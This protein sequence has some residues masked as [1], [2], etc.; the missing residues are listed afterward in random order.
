LQKTARSS[1][2]FRRLEAKLDEARLQSFESLVEDIH[3]RIDVREFTFATEQIQAARDI[4]QGAEQLRRLEE[5]EQRLRGAGRYE[6]RAI[7][8]LSPGAAASLEVDSPA[9]E[10]DHPAGPRTGAAV[11]GAGVT[12]MISGVLEIRTKQ[13]QNSR[14]ESGQHRIGKS[15]YKDY[16]GYIEN[17]PI[18][19][20]IN[21]TTPLL[22]WHGK[23]DGSVKWEQS[24]ELHLALRRLGKKHTMLIY[25]GEGHALAGPEACK[26]LSDRVHNWFD[27]YLKGIGS[28][29]L[30]N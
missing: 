4:A 21:S 8:P 12:D 1:T 24:L 27:Y 29:I 22:T 15:L 2:E 7:P 25:P 16:S 3:S 19:Q 11:A 6:K 28:D 5:C 26:D 23:Q 17:S 14:Y 10:L 9:T 20:A 30:R 13:A 18:A